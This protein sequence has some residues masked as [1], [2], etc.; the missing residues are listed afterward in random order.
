M[1]LFPEMVKIIPEGQRGVAKVEHFTITKDAAIMEM[2]S[3]R[4]STYPGRFVKLTVNGRLF[5]SD[6]TNEHRTNLEITYQARGHTLI[7]GLGI[8]MILTKILDKKEVRSVTVIEKY[9]DV[10]DLITPHFK[11]KKL[12]TICADIYEWRPPKGTKYDCI[13]FDIWADQSTDDLED[14]ARL[15]QRFK[16]YKAPGGWMDSWNRY[17]LKHRKRR[18]Y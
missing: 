3:S 2:I 15:H 5:M 13:Y 14:M 1:S 17:H 18:D 10:I 11:H 7:A 4:I 9:Q 16:S 12:T 8:G 6:T